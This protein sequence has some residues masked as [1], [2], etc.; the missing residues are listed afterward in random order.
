[1]CLSDNLSQLKTAE[2][3]SNERFA[4]LEAAL[5]SSQIER[6]RHEST[7]LLALDERTSA[8]SA[9]ASDCIGTEAN[10]DSEGSLALQ[11]S[12]SVPGVDPSS[13]V[14]RP[15]GNAVSPAAFGP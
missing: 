14:N 5:S 12:R 8:I 13:S 10:A 15:F 7:V 9:K 4:A 6:A 1:L 11:I 2:R 3:S